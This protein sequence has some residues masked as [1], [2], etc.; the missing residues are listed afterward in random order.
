MLHKSFSLRV[1][2]AVQATNSPW[3]TSK[4]QVKGK[5]LK[6]PSLQGIRRFFLLNQRNQRFA[7]R[8]SKTQTFEKSR[9][10]GGNNH[11]IGVF[12]TGGSP[13]I[14]FSAVNTSKSG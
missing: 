13:K 5:K 14:K 1:L 12:F 4:L 3:A 2:L 9:T 8:A 10:W 6:L 11:S 7:S